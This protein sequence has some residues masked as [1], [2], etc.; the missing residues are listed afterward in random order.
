[1]DEFLAQ[2]TIALV[3]ASRDPKKFSAAAAK[4]LRE[5]GYRII[6]VNP[7]AET[8]DGERCYP[9]L[10]SIE[11]PVGGA[12]VMVPRAETP[13]VIEDAAKAGIKRVWVQQGAESKKTADLGKEHGLSLVTGE[14]ILMFAGT[15]GF[16]KFHRWVWKL[17]GRLPTESQ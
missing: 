3:G 16:H 6:P 9:D 5:N 2:K 12:L 8:I 1:M 4:E 15:K 14:C 17:F 7:N 13:K 11:E 10:P